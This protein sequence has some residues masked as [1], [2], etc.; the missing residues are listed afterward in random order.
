MRDQET[1]DEIAQIDHELEILRSRQ[2]LVARWDRITKVYCAITLPVI[3]G[4][5][6]VLVYAWSSD[7][8]MAAFIFGMAAV[9]AAL[10]WVIGGW[11][12][13]QRSSAPPL[14]RSPSPF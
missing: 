5:S 10:M 6:T 8:L 11:T 9:V 13:G 4:L 1:A 3:A 2:A 12:I 14:S 7:I